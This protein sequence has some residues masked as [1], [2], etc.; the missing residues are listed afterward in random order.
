VSYRRT[1]GQLTVR[2][3][4][5]AASAREVTGLAGSPVS[6]VPARAMTSQ[7]LA[8]LAVSETPSRSRSA[9]VTMAVGLASAWIRM[10]EAIT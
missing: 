7:A 4:P 1:T 2:V 10:C 3:T 8:T 6:R 9:V 5:P